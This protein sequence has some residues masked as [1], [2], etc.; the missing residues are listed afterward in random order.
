MAVYLGRHCDD[1]GGYHY[2]RDKKF[3]D[4]YMILA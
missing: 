1:S 4:G 3:I 2:Y